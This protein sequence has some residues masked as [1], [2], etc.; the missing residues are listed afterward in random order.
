MT[1]SL[2]V[3]LLGV[4][5]VELAVAQLAVKADR[6]AIIAPDLFNI[7]LPHRL[8]LGFHFIIVLVLFLVFVPFG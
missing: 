6:L 5:V 7:V 2:H 1:S 4:G 3:H 8:N